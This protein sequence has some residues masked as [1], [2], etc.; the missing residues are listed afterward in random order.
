M[1][2]M[3][4]LRAIDCPDVSLTG[5]TRRVAYRI[6]KECHGFP[7]WAAVAMPKAK[8]LLEP[9]WAVADSGAVR[10]RFLAISEGLSPPLDQTSITPASQQRYSLIPHRARWLDRSSELP[11]GH[12]PVCAVCLSLMRLL[13]LACD[14]PA[15]S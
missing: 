5:A 1:P 9:A 12:R 4:P 3:I 10:L 8:R 11:F 14:V 2:M 7:C 6:H 15:I 13:T